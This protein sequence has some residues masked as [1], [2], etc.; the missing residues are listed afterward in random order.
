VSAKYRGHSIE[1]INQFR[2]ERGFTGLAI[3]CR[4]EAYKETEA[5]LRVDG[6]ILLQKLTSEQINDFLAQAGPNL[7]SL[8]KALQQDNM[9]RQMAQ[10][11]LMLNMM[12]LAYSNYEGDIV[13]PDDNN[14][15]ALSARRHHLFATY[16]QRRLSSRGEGDYAAA[17]IQTWLTWLAQKMTAHHQSQFFIEQIQP[18]W[19]NS[20]S[21]YWLYTIGSR[22]IGGGII[23]FI[24]WFM[25]MRFDPVSFT[26]EPLRLLT[27]SWPLPGNWLHAI[28][29]VLLNLI[30]GLV[31]GVID[32]LFFMRRHGQANEAEISPKQGWQHLSLVAFSILVTTF[33]LFTLFSSSP[34]YT[35]AL[36]AG[37][38]E[39]VFF[40]V[41]FGYISHGQSLRTEIRT[42]EALT[43]SWTGAARGIILGLFLG[44]LAGFSIH[45]LYQFPPTSVS[46]GVGFGLFFA[47]FGGLQHNQL[48][49]T[50]RPNQGIWLSLKNGLL[51]AL[52]F[53]ST[54]GIAIGGTLF[55]G[56]KW[57]GNPFSFILTYVLVFG[58]AA[59]LLYGLIDVLK[60]FV[61]R[62]LLWAT[63]GM[64]WRYAHFLDDA[65]RRILLYKVGGGYQFAHRLLQDYFVAP[66]KAG[67]G[68]AEWDDM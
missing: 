42:I 5:R 52:V 46:V 7:A 11:P 34:N 26:P 25:L 64:P 53:G 24:L 6:A 4:E 30:L 54:L 45:I 47:L 38:F 29:L 57:T 8:R 16:V 51:A 21:W 60:H 33:I 9:L 14:Q 55:I 62:L 59:G 17:Q 28:N 27:A 19:L 41:G 40:T 31:V 1:A 65:A 50:S 48:P 23:S 18:S 10:S 15:E 63:G 35:V 20:V 58:L 37:L 13:S 61:V 36:F 56:F 32:G 44:L 49:K 3:C 43:W 22:L 12:L 39:A 67:T 68:S 2:T 66:N